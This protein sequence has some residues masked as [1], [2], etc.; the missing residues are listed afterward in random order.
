MAAKFGA[1]NCGVV[2]KNQSD[3]FKFTMATEVDQ[4]LREVQREYLDFLDDEV[5]S[6]SLVTLEF[7]VKTTEKCL[8]KCLPNR[9]STMPVKDSLD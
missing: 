4:R 8:C 9:L 6:M 2:D 7:C 3:N 1:K 5:D